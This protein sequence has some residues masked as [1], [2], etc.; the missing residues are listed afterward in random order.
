M[1]FG[2]GLERVIQTM[3][4]Q[5]VP[6]PRP[7]HPIVFLVALGAKAKSHCFSLLHEL[8][9][10]GIPAQMDFSD[11]KL[12]KIM[13]YADQINAQYVVVIGDHELEERQIE[14]K[15]MATGQKIKIALDDLI[16]ILKIEIRSRDFMNL[17]EE[18][19]HPFKNESEA[20][21]FIE[22]IK[23]SLNQTKELASTLQQKLEQFK[24]LA[25]E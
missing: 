5:E 2:T 4:N 22:K 19:S 16:S 11:R 17:W 1:G 12:G 14:L 7:E 3:I 18:F 21:F 15:Q 8:R 9:Q 10:N 23:V 24:Q 6:L 13:Q 20:R 25:D